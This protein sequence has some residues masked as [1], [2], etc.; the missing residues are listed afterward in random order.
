MNVNFAEEPGARPEWRTQGDLQGLPHD[1]RGGASSSPGK[2][3]IGLNRIVSCPGHLIFEL[4]LCRP[5]HRG[6]REGDEDE[7]RRN[8]Q[9]AAGGEEAEEGSRI[10]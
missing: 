9:G 5:I 1:C 10:P 4:L 3:D 6:Q 8:P 2:D 7:V